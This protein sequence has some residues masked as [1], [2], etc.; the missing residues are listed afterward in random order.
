MTST[1]SSDL[2]PSTQVSRAA[3]QLTAA[4]FDRLR[5]KIARAEANLEDAREQ[6]RQ[7]MEA[8]ETESLGWSR[9]SS[10]WRNSKGTSWT[11][12]RCWTAR[13]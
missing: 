11:W 6:V 12:R 5:E 1:A 10:T 13:C 2:H 8:R 3:P 4:G 7:H 9:H